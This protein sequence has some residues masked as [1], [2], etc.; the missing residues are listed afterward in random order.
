MFDFIDTQNTLSNKKQE[1]T[2]QINKTKV[3]STRTHQSYAC[4]F[5]VWKATSVLK[6]QNYSFKNMKFTTWWPP[7]K[8]AL[9]S[10]S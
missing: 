2:T 10:Q 4:D 3:K 7:V 6:V 8:D 5:V 9:G 1:K